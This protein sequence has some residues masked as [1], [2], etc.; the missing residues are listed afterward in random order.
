M[1][2][3]LLAFT[4]GIF[5]VGASAQCTDLIIS[6]YVEGSGNNKAMELFNTTDQAIDLTGYTLERFSNGATTS[7]AGGVL[8]L[9]GTTIP[10]YSTLVIVNGQT[11]FENGG[12]SPPCDSVLQTL[13]DILDNPYPAVTYM[14]GN[15]AV[16]LFKDNS[17]TIVDIFGKV[18]EDPGS[19][20]TDDPTAGYTDAN[21]GTWWTR[22]QTLIRK[23]TVTTGVTNPSITEFNVTLEYDS[24]PNGTWTELNQHTCDCLVGVEDVVVD[25]SEGIKFYPSLIGSDGETVLLASSGVKQIQIF[26]ITGNLVYSES[27][28]SFSQKVP[29][30]IVNAKPGIYLARVTLETGTVRTSKIV[31]R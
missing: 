16:V 18:G 13:A 8:D 24:L 7:S 29:V 23:P 5:A 19:A 22:D 1:K 21:G 14:N 11:T 3:V 17:V 12:T 20:W 9:T 27:R 30:N 4:F 6:E 10:A 31:K 25:K 2:K 15:D 28:Q 26:D